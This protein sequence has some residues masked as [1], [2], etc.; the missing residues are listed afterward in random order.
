MTLITGANRTEVTKGDIDDLCESDRTEITDGNVDEITGGN[1]SDTAAGYNELIGST[2][3]VGS[4]GVNVLEVLSQFMGFT[5][6]ALK[7]A[8]RR[9]RMA[10][11]TQ[12]VS[13]T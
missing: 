5:I 13:N 3:W 11:T 8:P 6:S 10:Q 7:G 2:V 4:A 1:H 12:Y 9:N